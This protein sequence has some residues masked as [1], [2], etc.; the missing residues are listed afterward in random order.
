MRKATGQLIRLVRRDSA[1]PADEQ[2]G[3]E[4]AAG[5]A[6]PPEWE[7]A[8]TEK[9][10]ELVGELRSKNRLTTRS[11]DLVRLYVISWFE[12]H[13]ARANLAQWGAIVSHPRTG[14]PIRNPHLKVA[15]DAE[16]TCVKLVREL[17]L[18]RGR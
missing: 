13:Q 9:W 6:S 17:G 8:W 3:D 14:L 2:A 15:R 12:A 5:A 4:Q 1:P 10:D 18:S 11:L 7:E 16:A